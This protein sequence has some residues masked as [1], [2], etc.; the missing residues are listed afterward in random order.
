MSKEYL[1]SSQR[2][3]LLD[4][5]IIAVNFRLASGA[6][7]TQKF[8]FDRITS[9]SELFPLVISGLA[10]CIRDRFAGYDG[11]LTVAK[12]ATRL[13]DPLS[14]ELGVE[15]VLSDYTTDGDGMKTFAVLP[16]PA[17]ERV[18]I[19]DDVFTRGTNATKT[20]I[21]AADHA[22]ET[23]GVAVVLDRSG[24]DAP[25]ILEDIAVASVVQRELN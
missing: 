11:I 10:A 9:E 25:T 17:V 6:P 18:V 3:H 14:Q 12:G 16:N 20:A 22:I 21:A 8:D 19:V 7:A 24:F 1:N 13:G 5:G 23:V 4:T 15:H 2:E